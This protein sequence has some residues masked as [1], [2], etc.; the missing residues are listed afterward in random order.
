MPQAAPPGLVGQ[1]VQNLPVNEDAQLAITLDQSDL[2]AQVNLE[3][4]FLPAHITGTL[5]SEEFSFIAL[6]LNGS[7][8][9]VTRPW[10]FAV[11]GK[12]GRWS[13]LLDPQFFS[14]GRKHA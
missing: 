3:A 11:R 13:A 4:Q 12:N 10:S 7:V 2:L 9:A 14:A 5:H 8:R 6:A 1:R